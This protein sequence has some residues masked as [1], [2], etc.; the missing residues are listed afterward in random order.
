MF[1]REAFEALNEEEKESFYQTVIRN[2][3]SP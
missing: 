3:P 1:F 2:D